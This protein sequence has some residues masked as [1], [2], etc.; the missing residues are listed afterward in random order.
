MKKT[1]PLPL[2]TEEYQAIA[3]HLGSAQVPEGTLTLHQLRGF[4]YAVACSPTA[5]TPGDWLPV[6]WGSEDD[7]KDP[8]ETAAA[9]EDANPPSGLS[10]IPPEAESVLP[11]IV[12]LFGLT[13]RAVKDEA[14]KLPAECVWSEDDEEGRALR[15]WCQGL[16]VGHGWLED[17]WNEA[18]DDMKKRED[19]TLGQ[20][21]AAA[22]AM[23]ILFADVEGALARAPNPEELRGRL[24]M[25]ASTILPNSLA[26]YA[27]IGRELLRLERLRA[28]NP[29]QPKI[30]R[31][32]P[33]PCGS[34]KKF[35]KCCG[36]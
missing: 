21:V 36:A 11:H 7:L 26:I 15:E 22:L 24:P 18:L 10:R 35:K 13:D 34:G 19:L 17:V 4:L 14:F 25:I 2:P 6:I 16:M 5:L 33:C 31:N 32:D 30:G 8:A 29:E 27:R 28:Q 23:P 12:Y 9:S 3:D 1:K 20:E